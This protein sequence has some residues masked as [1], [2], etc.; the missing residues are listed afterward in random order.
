MTELLTRWRT[1]VDET[2]ATARRTTPGPLLV[3]TGAFLTGLIGL[4]VA[5]PPPL[6]LGPAFLVILVLAAAP[7]L[8]PRGRLTTAVIL[9]AVIGW[10][11][12]VFAYNQSPQFLRVVILAAALYLQ[13]NLAALAA[14]LPYDAVIAPGVLFRWLARA[15]LVLLLTA[16]LALFAVV[17]PLYLSGRYLAASLAGLALMGLIVGYLAR[18]VGR[19]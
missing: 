6:V 11:I 17:A 16:G 7:A 19:R 5:W 15:G 3:R 18:L 9:L 8:A 2:V 4:L 1:R 13:H 14:V 10:E 12:G